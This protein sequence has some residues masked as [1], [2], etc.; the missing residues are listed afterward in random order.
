MI[1]EQDVNRLASYCA[2][3][4]VGGSSWAI[5]QGSVRPVQDL[6]LKKLKEEE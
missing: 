3:R 5:Y 4:C 6:T 2:P 1:D